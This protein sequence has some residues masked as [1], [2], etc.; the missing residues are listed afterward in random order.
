MRVTRGPSTDYVLL[1]GFTR[2]IELQIAD[3]NNEKTR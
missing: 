3:A 2:D 1:H